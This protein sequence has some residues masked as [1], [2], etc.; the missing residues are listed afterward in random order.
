VP[1]RSITEEFGYDV[2]WN[3]ATETIDVTGN[4]TVVKMVIDQ[5]WMLVNGTQVNLEAAPEI[6]DFATMV[7]MRALADAF[8]LNVDYDPFTGT[9]VVSDGAINL[10]SSVSQGNTILGQAPIQLLVGKITVNQATGNIF[11]DDDVFPDSAE[12]VGGA[13][14]VKFWD[15][16]NLLGGTVDTTGGTVKILLGG[17]TLTLDANN[18]FI[19]ATSTRYVKASALDAAFTNVKYTVS[20][21]VGILYT[22]T[23]TSGQ[24]DTLV[25]IAGK[26][27]G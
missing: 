3:G 18:S 5:D 23:L 19:D 12:M 7:P 15:A 21:N 25:F 22:G 11:I 4:G 2:A 8:N 27:L 17:Q 16:V 26:A 10:A 20:N 6:V 1:L 24:I 13:A 14:Y 9:V